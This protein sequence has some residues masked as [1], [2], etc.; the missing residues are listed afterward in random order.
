MGTRSDAATLD[1]GKDRHHQLGEGRSWHAHAH[2]RRT[3]GVSVP[4]RAGRS[5]PGPEAEHRAAVATTLGW[6]DR[7]ALEG[8]YADALA[9]LETLLAIGEQLN[10][11]YLTK[12]A[13]WLDARRRQPA[14]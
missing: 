2:A 9:W 12:R 10:P 14:A 8:D 6:A 3:S 1:D 13:A 5:R 7:A 4:G 11:E